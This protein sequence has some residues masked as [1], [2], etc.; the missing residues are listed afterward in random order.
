MGLFYLIRG[1]IGT[2]RVNPAMRFS[3]VACVC[4]LTNST[5]T[6]GCADLIAV[7]MRLTEFFMCVVSRWSSNYALSAA[8]TAHLAARTNYPR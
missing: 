3:H 1:G 2:S 8:T 4:G 7:S 6:D 5:C